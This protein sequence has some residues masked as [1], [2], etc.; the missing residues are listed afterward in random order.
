MVTTVC[1]QSLYSGSHVSS[2]HTLLSLQ[3]AGSP[4]TLTVVLWYASS[5][6]TL[7]VVLQYAGNPCTLVVVLAV[8]AL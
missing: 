2:P 5:S 4:W 3:Y 1:W 8:P 7:A 6:C